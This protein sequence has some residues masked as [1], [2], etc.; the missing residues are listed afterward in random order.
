MILKK[1]F[2][3]NKNSFYE[4]SI[5]LDTVSEYKKGIIKIINDSSGA[6]IFLPIKLPNVI[7][8]ANSSEKNHL[9][10]FDTPDDD[11]VTVTMYVLGLDIATISITNINCEQ[12]LNKINLTRFRQLNEIEFTK[13]YLDLFN[14]CSNKKLD[15]K[16]IQKINEEYS[17]FKNP[18]YFESFM[19]NIL[20][21]DPCYKALTQHKQINNEIELC[22]KITVLFLASSIHDESPI[23]LRTK[24][25]PKNI[26]FDDNKYYC[27][28]ATKYGYPYDRP[29]DYY[30]KKLSVTK[31]EG[32]D[33]I[34]LN[35]GKDNY[36][37]NSLCTYVEKYI[38]ELI[39][40][41]VL[42][43]VQILHVQNN[44][45]NG[46]VASLVAKE[47]KIKFIYDVC[48]NEWFST[49]NV[50]GKILPDDKV[51][52]S[53]VAI[54]KSGV[55]KVV[56]DAA[57]KIVM[58]PYCY[59]IYISMFDT[60]KINL[61]VIPTGIDT[62]KFKENK[63]NITKIK[64]IIQT[65]SSSHSKLINTIRLESNNE[66]KSTSNLNNDEIIKPNVIHNNKKN[67]TRVFLGNGITYNNNYYN[68]TT[69]NCNNI[70][71]GSNNNASCGNNNNNNNNS[72]CSNIDQNNIIVRSF[73][74]NEE[75]PATFGSQNSLNKQKIIYRHKV[76]SSGNSCRATNVIY[77]GTNN[78]KTT[79]GVAPDQNNRASEIINGAKLIIGYFGHITESQNKNI[80][81]LLEATSFICKNHHIVVGCVLIH[82]KN[83]EIEPIYLKKII[84]LI[85]SLN[86][87]KHV[88]IISGVSEH[89]KWAYVDY[90]NV[91]Y[92]DQYE[93]NS[94]EYDYDSI[95]QKLLSKGRGIIVTDKFY[96]R[97]GNFTSTLKENVCIR[98][99]NKE[100]EN[101][102]LLANT[103]N[104][105]AT[106]K[107]KSSHSL[108]NYANTNF[109]IPSVCNTF[110]KIYDDLINYE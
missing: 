14:K 96:D 58:S 48:I 73:I 56:F 90:I 83:E 10:Y 85:I 71:G 61:K 47:L 41:C 94:N 109:S 51:M 84:R 107:S 45:I 49:V 29:E 40:V 59:G 16:L 11:I 93:N 86:L 44:Y 66:F 30:N 46:L 57:D 20:P 43:N 106:T 79:N 54:M 2:P 27:I 65:V 69:L 34:P 97:Y 23:T 37:T 88:S 100:N 68:N 38:I 62:S 28:L 32:V 101:N 80:I 6:L 98:L 8:S 22:K 31:F 18:N 70:N 87:E 63:D 53:D 81:D 55:E 99:D 36:N 76:E 4:L 24:A 52:L 75:N 12:M 82:D 50:K 72:N 7:F 74:H 78:S 21:N 64:G 60:E 108:R 9:I 13:Y 92:F 95:L 3:V 25:I 104:N 15:N 77:S 35:Q 105:I 110:C 67:T 19:E 33:Y 17:I 89:L 5:N 39:K 102:E 103:I 26:N 1:T 91:Y 42:N